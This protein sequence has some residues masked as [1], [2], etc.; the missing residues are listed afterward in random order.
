MKNIDQ[1]QTGDEEI[2]S[3]T[4]LKKEAEEYQALGIRLTDLAPQVLAELP[5]D[6][7]LRDA[8]TLAQRIRNKREGYRRQLQFIGKLMR[9]RDCE[10]IFRALEL[11]DAKHHQANLHFH[12][13]E[14]T[15]DAMIQQG[16]EA[17]QQFVD[18]NPTADRQRL[19]QLA[20]TA[21]REQSTNKP[22]KAS[23]ELF[24]YLREICK[25]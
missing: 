16:D 4:Q 3:R 20:R 21:V 24:K 15:R 5:I 8:I 2:I 17:I 9:S 23:R 18:D 6:D 25:I 10:V 7:A 14:Q 19:R 12:R 13:L 1:D 22:P 11:H